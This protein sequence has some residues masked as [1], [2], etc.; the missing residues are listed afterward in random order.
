MIFKV[1]KDKGNV[2]LH[3]LD[4]I[5]EATAKNY[6]RIIR[7]ALPPPEKASGNDITYPI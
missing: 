6:K 5:L 1:N 3:H 7:I 4:Q 2:I